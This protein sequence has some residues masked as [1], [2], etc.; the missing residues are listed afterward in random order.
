[1]TAHTV[2]TDFNP[3]TEFRKCWQ[4]INDLLPTLSEIQK[5][6]ITLWWCGK[7]PKILLKFTA[8]AL[9]KDVG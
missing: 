4:Q 9:Y 6:C 2:V 5:Y 7:L 3:S 1:M 8:N